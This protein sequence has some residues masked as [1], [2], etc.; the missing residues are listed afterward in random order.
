MASSS[1]P[2]IR[3][4]GVRNSWLTFEKNVVLARSSSARDSARRLRLG[5]ANAQV[6]QRRHAALAEHLL[7]GF[8]D[9]RQDAADAAGHAL[10]RDRAV[11]DQ[12]VRLL[13]EPVAV[14][15][16]ENVLVPGRRAVK[17]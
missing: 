14:D 5:G 13:V 9:G 4:S 15:D 2:R 6:T 7:G 1:G 3:V 17:R 12:P 10:I 16:E 8:V 11:G